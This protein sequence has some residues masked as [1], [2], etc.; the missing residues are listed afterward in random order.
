MTIFWISLVPSY[1][2]D[3][4]HAPVEIARSAAVAFPGGGVRRNFGLCECA[5]RLPNSP[6]L[7]S[8]TPMA[9]CYPLAEIGP[10]AGEGAIRRIA[11]RLIRIRPLH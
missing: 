8:D 9:E 6:L 4:A 2:P 11:D 5:C 10:T 1:Q 7:L 3:L